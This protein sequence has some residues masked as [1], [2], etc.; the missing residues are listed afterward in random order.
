MSSR[1][2]GIVLPVAGLVLVLAFMW[3][4]RPLDPLVRS[5]PPVE[6]VSVESVRLAPGLIVL[7][8]RADGS[9]PTHIAQV[10]VDGAYRAFTADP[11]QTVGR[12]NRARIEIPYPWIEGESHHI[13]LVTGTGATFEHAIEAAVTTG[14][15]SHGNVRLLL[16]IGLL[17]GP[18]PV[19]LGLLAFPALRYSSGRWHGFVLSVTLGLLLFL[20]IDTLGEGLDVAES[21]IG[22]LRSD[23]MVWISMIATAAI[24]LAV[25]RRSG[26]PPTGLV[27]SGYIALG[28]GLHNLGEGLVVGA[29]LSTGAASLAAFLVV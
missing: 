29:A 26:R 6:E 8:I 15:V 14:T 3:I 23:V 1:L 18:V 11:S 16:L 27:L 24:L 13:V 4:G 22:R 25:G 2:A 7:D 9:G 10:Q 5:A 17:L 21:A 19:G 28:I 12:M 20:F